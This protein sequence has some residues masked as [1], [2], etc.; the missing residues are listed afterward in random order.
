MYSY[1][2]LTYSFRTVHTCITFI[3]FSIFIFIF[4]FFVFHYL[5]YR[6]GHSIFFSLFA[7]DGSITF[8]LL[9]DFDKSTFLGI[10]MFA[11][12]INRCFR[13]VTKNPFLLSEEVIYESQ[14]D[15]S[16]AWGGGEG[17]GGRGV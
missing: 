3:I 14:T 11:S 9:I 12:S 10:F 8:S 16:G 7:I 6:G 17:G 15:S 1:S 4:I 2:S 13:Q 5:I